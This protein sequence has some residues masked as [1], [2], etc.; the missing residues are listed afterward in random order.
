MP[1]IN[2]LGG[3]LAATAAPNPSTGAEGN[4]SSNSKADAG[5]QAASNDAVK[6]VTGVKRPEAEGTD[7]RTGRARGERRKFAELA[8]SKNARVDERTGDVVD[9]KSRDE[10][11]DA[12]AKAAGETKE[13]PESKARLEKAL[14]D[15]FAPR[16]K[17][18][19]QPQAKET[20]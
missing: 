2:Q 1:G 10:G 18:Q 12:A 11:D 4:Q 20:D 7:D 13:S 9:V 16:P 14:S 6:G 8:R 5:L 3:A 19:A 15:L 17:A